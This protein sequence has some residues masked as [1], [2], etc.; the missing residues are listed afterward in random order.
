[1]PERSVVADSGRSW[2]RTT[3]SLPANPRS[4]CRRPSRLL[5]KRH[6]THRRQPNRARRPTWLRFVTAAHSCHSPQADLT[7]CIHYSSPAANLDRAANADKA[8][9]IGNSL[10]TCDITR[11]SCAII[12]EDLD[13]CTRSPHFYRRCAQPVRSRTI[14]L[15]W[16][17][18][19]DIQS[20]CGR[21]KAVLVD[22]P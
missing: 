9:C 11:D 22:L 2:V 4:S 10:H 6:P 1:M 21:P 17:D 18:L 16:Q 12:A 3:V 8:V 7:A 14:T 19:S 20:R 5:K 15:R 13:A